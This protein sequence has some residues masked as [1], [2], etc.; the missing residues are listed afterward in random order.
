MNRNN[1]L[2]NPDDV[3]DILNKQYTF[4]D[5]NQAYGYGLKQG[6]VT[7]N[8]DKNSCQQTDAVHKGMG[9]YRDELNS[10]AYP[11]IYFTTYQLNITDKRIST[12]INKNSFTNLQKNILVEN[13]DMYP[14]CSYM[15]ISPNQKYYLALNRFLPIP[16]LPIP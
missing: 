7:N 14:G 11:A 12:L 8:F 6:C 15:L 3:S 9:I 16:F 13:V 4:A 2:T 5:I 1:K 10:K